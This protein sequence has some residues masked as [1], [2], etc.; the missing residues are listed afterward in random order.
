MKCSNSMNL[1][2]MIWRFPSQKQP[3]DLF[4]KKV[5][6]KNSQNIQDS[7]CMGVSFLIKEFYNLIKKIN[8][9][10]SFF[11]RHFEGHISRGLRPLQ[12]Y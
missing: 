2:K 6:L 9:A 5:A 7:T 11:Q 12:L 10:K 3:L 4:Y 8:S 1:L